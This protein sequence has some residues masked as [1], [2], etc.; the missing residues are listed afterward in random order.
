VAL[1]VAG[2]A[3]LRRLAAPPAAPFFAL[4]IVPAL[5]FYTAVH[6]GDPGYVLSVV[7][8]IFVL[9]A[10]LIDRWPAPGRAAAAALALAPGVLFLAGGVYPFS[11]DVLAAHDRSV[12]DLLA[13][14][15]ALPA[16]ASVVASGPA[17]TVAAYYVRDRPV[18]FSGD[19]PEVL[20]RGARAEPPPSRGMALVIF[21]PPS[22]ET[23]AVAAGA[24]YPL[25]LYDLGLR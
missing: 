1:L 15:Q 16:D 6:V 12:R 7:P 13:V 18:R 2:L 10:A 4:W 21:A 25:V 5:L 3:R 8:T 17:Y 24:A 14:T 22:I 23:T 20:A 11:R 19:A 9:F